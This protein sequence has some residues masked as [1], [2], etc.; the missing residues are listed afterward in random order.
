MH[1][2]IRHVYI[3]I[4]VSRLSFIKPNNTTRNFLNN[5][6]VYYLYWR[7]ELTLLK[8]LLTYIITRL[9]HIYI[10]KLWQPFHNQCIT[11][12]P[13]TCTEFSY[14]PLMA[15]KFFC[16]GGRGRWGWFFKMHNFYDLW[17]YN[18]WFYKIVI[19]NFNR[20]S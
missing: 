18:L 10:E 8:T 3:Y 19:L 11:S 16:H 15:V 7:I 17:K 6:K 9:Y 12:N 13:Y 1:F 5:N 20:K 4:K 2:F 14:S